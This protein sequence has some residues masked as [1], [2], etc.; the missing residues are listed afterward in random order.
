MGGKFYFALCSLKKGEGK[1]FSGVEFRFLAKKRN[2]LFWGCIGGILFF[3]L[4]GGVS[5]YIRVEKK[6][7]WRASESDVDIKKAT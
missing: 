5:R 3:F 1:L 4:G 7:P 6:V 2:S